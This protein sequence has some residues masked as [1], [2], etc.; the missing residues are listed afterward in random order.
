MVNDDE[1]TD[2]PAPDEAQPE[3]DRGQEE[4]AA[5]PDVRPAPRPPRPP[6]RR[7]IAR[8]DRRRRSARKGS[9]RRWLFGIGGG[10]IA[11]MLILGLFLPSVRGLGGTTRTTNPE[12]DAPRSGTAVAVQPGETIEPGT[13]HGGYS[14]LPPTS[15][16]RYAEPAPWGVHDTQIADETVVRNLQVGAV[17]FNYNLESEAEVTDLRQL[18]EALPGYPSCYLVHPYAGV[19][20]GSVTLTAW[21]WTQEVA[22]VDRFL[23]QTFADDHLNQGA[24]YLGPSCGAL[25]ATP[26]PDEATSPADT[27]QGE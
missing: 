3:P 16:P 14:T 7:T 19:P 11:I 27:E 6:S 17:V 20:T 24:E 1:R 9:R 2:D 5:K 21:G 22:G 26:T 23:L 12:D 25:P 15:G 8:D 10:T 13:S 18:V 4:A